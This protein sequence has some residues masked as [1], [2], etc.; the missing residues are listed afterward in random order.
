MRKKDKEIYASGL[1]IMECLLDKLSGKPNHGRT[2]I[3]SECM[4]Y[5]EM[6]A[7]KIGKAGIQSD[8]S[9]VNEIQT[10]I[11]DLQLL[12]DGNLDIREIYFSIKNL[13]NKIKN[14]SIQYEVVFMP[15]KASMWD[16]F[17][18]IYRSMMEDKDV[19]VRVLPIPYYS[20]EKETGVMNFHY[21]GEFFPEDIYITNYKKYDLE[22]E[23]PDVIFIHNPYDDMNRVTQVESEYFSSNLICYTNHLVYIPYDV[24]SNSTIDRHY[25]LT[26]GVRNA[27]RVFVQSENIRKEYS[28]WN[29]P[30]KIVAL[31]SPKIDAVINVQNAWSRTSD[32][33]R[34]KCRDKD[35]ILYNTHLAGIMAEGR[36]QLEKI[37][38]VYD[39]FRRREDVVLLWRPHP[40]S[41][42]TAE[43]LNPDFLQEYLKL[44]EDMKELPNVIY[45]DTPDLNRSIAISDGY[46]GDKSSLV[47][48]YALTGKPIL[49]ESSQNKGLLKEQQNLLLSSCGKIVNDTLWTCYDLRNG[50]FKVDVKT[51]RAEFISSIPNV[52][53][54]VEMAF[55]NIIFWKGNLFFIPVYSEYFI[56]YNIKKNEFKT[57]RCENFKKGRIKFSTVIQNE[58]KVYLFPLMYP[59]NVKVLDLDTFEIETMVIDY[60]NL[61][62]CICN[63]DAFVFSVYGEAAENAIW[64]PFYQENC[65]LKVC[66]N[67]MQVFSLDLNSNGIRSMRYDGTN[68]WIAPMYGYELICW[69][70]RDGILER[71]DCKEKMEAEALDAI[72]DIVIFQEDIWLI[73]KK[74]KHIAK[75]NRIDKSLKRISISSKIY[76]G[77]EN[78]AESFCG[79]E[80]V[81]NFLYLF[82]YRTNC[83]LRIHL[84]TEEVKE[85]SIELPIE[86]DEK[87]RTEQKYDVLNKEINMECPEQFFFKNS[88]CS[89]EQFI[90]ILREYTKEKREVQKEI[91]C[92]MTA[93][94]DGTAGE[95][96]WKTIKEKIK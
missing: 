4:Q 72:E 62:S 37:R 48:M 92:Q 45:D 75:Y 17:D 6:L 74:A 83:M 31:G 57:K 36:R 80:I 70:E 32:E 68:F 50:L 52:G 28:K 54:Q 12:L 35:V 79:K 16:S 86:C 11:T 39:V 33:W 15:Y 82:Q 90:N 24:V 29:N 77:F 71:I 19:N 9:L 8:M 76:K 44:I 89:I 40:L 23:E 78:Y 67:I 30:E 81:G 3:L 73:P 61:K 18:S 47:L 42:Q 20:M 41:I 94:I 13:K 59:D 38:S 85:V 88:T 65:V 49:I 14:T 51:G 53:L 2:L 25:C 5:L 55:S 34:E 87:W 56:S 7:D 27:W 64:V 1:Q 46:M 69:N 66:D 10:S 60:S 95:R 91:F 26:P 84:L 58:N 63:I 21:E 22:Q 93:N 43:A 96:I